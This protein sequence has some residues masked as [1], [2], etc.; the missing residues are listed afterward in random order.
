VTLQQQHNRD[1][2]G[3]VVNALVQRID[4]DPLVAVALRAVADRTHDV[5]LRSRIERHLSR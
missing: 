4:D 2:E 5:R 1:I 3:R